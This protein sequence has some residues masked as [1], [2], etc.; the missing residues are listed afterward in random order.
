[1]KVFISTKTLDKIKK[2][3]KDQKPGRI[4]VRKREE[5]DPET[6]IIPKIKLSENT[7]K[8]HN[9]HEYYTVYVSKKRLFD[10]AKYMKDNEIEE[11]GILPIIPAILAGITALTGITGAATG[12]A[13]TILDKKHNDEI[14]TEEKRKNDEMLAIAKGSGGL[15]L[16]PWKSYGMGIDVKDIINSFNLSDVG[17]KTLR[18]IIK[19]LSQHLQIE[20]Y[21]NGIYLHPFQN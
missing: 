17:K 10:I 14:L 11:G 15:Y 21:A 9:G 2:M 12:V 20:K 6:N 7:K 1:M 8:L 13:K 4:S 16:N 18:N 5:G 19:N 3:I